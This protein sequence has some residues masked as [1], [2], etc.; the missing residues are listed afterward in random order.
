MG[1]DSHRPPLSRFSWNRGEQSST[2]TTAPAEQA[3]GQAMISTSRNE[4]N[5]RITIDDYGLRGPELQRY[6]DPEILLPSCGLGRY[7]CVLILR[8]VA[9]AQ[10]THA[11]R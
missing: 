1:V 9:F 5:I 4:D 10:M 11:G 6:S 7:Q 3:S 2:S 8:D